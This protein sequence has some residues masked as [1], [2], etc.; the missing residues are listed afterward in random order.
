MVYNKENLKKNFKNRF[1]LRAKAHVLFFLR[2]LKSN[3]GVLT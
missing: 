2:P 1:S 3:V